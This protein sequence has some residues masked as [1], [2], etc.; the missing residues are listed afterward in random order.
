M[1]SGYWIALEVI[2]EGKGKVITAKLAEAYGETREFVRDVLELSAAIQFRGRL[3]SR[4]D[5]EHDRQDGTPHAM[6]LPGAAPFPVG[7]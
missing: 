5:G 2:A 4:S 1:G 3:V 6:L 7:P